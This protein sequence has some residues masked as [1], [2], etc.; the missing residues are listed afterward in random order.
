MVDQEISQHRAAEGSDER[1]HHRVSRAG[2]RSAKTESAKN[3]GHYRSNLAA[4][5]ARATGGKLPTIGFLGADASAFSPWTA[6]FVAHLRERA[7]SRTVTSRSSIVGRGRT[8]RY[9]EITARSVG[10][11]LK[12][13]EDR[14]R[15]PQSVR[16]CTTAATIGASTGPRIRNRAP[17]LNFTS[18]TPGDR[19]NLVLV[20]ASV[21]TSN[22]NDANRAAPCNCRR[23][24]NSW[25]ACIPASRATADA[26]APGSIAA[27]TMRSFSALDH[28]RRC[29]TEVTISTC[30]F[31]IGLPPISIV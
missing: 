3:S 31:V 10:S 9:A 4:G 28:L 5:G 26:T 15:F 1:C 16:A 24:R 6:A 23:Q 13:P 19:G 17:V 8:E 30:V 7:G 22:V 11:M 2:R 18:I 25:L 20:A 21:G 29:R 12:A 14:H 27:A